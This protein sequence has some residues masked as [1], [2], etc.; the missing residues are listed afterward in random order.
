MSRK[1]TKK[2]VWLKLFSE[3]DTALA[4]AIHFC[5]RFVT[6]ESLENGRDF[7]EQKKKE[8]YS[9]FPI[10]V[11][12]ELFGAKGFDLCKKCL[13]NTC[14]NQRCNG[15][16]QCLGVIETEKDCPNGYHPG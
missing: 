5:E 4:S 6:E 7:I 8:L 2:E 15:C 13:C 9:E 11:A 12:R 16:E 1:L 14:I 3:N 10:N